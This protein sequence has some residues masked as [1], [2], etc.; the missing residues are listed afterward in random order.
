MEAQLR[1]LIQAA[2]PVD[3][4]DESD[5][6]R[7]LTAQL[8]AVAAAGVRALQ[9]QLLLDAQRLLGQSLAGPCQQCRRKGEGAPHWQAS[10]CP[11]LHA[12]RGP[13]RRLCCHYRHPLA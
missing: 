1:R 6:G 4:A 10:Y 13:G 11:H 3:A 2:P 8:V 7:A 12:C 5:A 9:Q